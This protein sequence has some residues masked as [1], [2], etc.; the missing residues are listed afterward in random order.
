LHTN[1]TNNFLIIENPSNF[2]FPSEMMQYFKEIQWDKIVWNTFGLPAFYSTFSITG[3]QLYFEKGQDNEIKLRK[4]DH[5]G[6][7]IASTV[8]APDSSTEIYVLTFELSFCGGILTKNELK[9]FKKQSKAEYEEGFRSFQNSMSKNENRRRSWW[10][11]FL[12]KPYYWTISGITMSFVLA[13][14][15]ILKFIC[16]LVGFLLPIKL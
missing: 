2:T 10:F 15:A 14:Q 7:V 5:T 13:I 3:N 4:E 6:Q 12:Y 9:D 11:K 16:W 1:Q 8:I